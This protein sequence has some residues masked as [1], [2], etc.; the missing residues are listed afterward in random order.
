[1][2]CL[3]R[4]AADLAQLVPSVQAQ[5]NELVA[6][7]AKRGERDLLDGVLELLPGLQVQPDPRS[8]EVLLEAHCCLE[9]FHEV[10]RGGSSAGDMY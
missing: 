7:L 9:N 4:F 3:P 1:M 8:Y 5:I 2:R 10:P 6:G